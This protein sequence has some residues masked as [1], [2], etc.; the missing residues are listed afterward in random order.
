MT[1]ASS[2]EKRPS[3]L[4]RCF[5]K[6]LRPNKKQGSQLPPKTESIDS[7]VASSHN[8]PSQ[9]GT[10]NSPNPAPPIKKV[11]KK[12]PQAYNSTYV[13]RTQS[14]YTPVGITHAGN[15]GFFD[16]HISSAAG[17]DAS[18]G[19][20]APDSYCD[21]GIDTGGGCD[22]GGGGDSGGGG[23]DSGGG[24]DGGNDYDGGGGCFSPESLIQLVSERKAIKDLHPGDT[25]IC[26]ASG[27]TATVR[28]I[29]VYPIPGGRTKMIRLPNG[30]TVSPTHPI[31]DEES[32]ARNG[33][34]VFPKDLV[35]GRATEVILECKEV[36]DILLSDLN[37]AVVNGAVCALLGHE[38][39]GDTAHQLW[40]DGTRIEKCLSSLDSEGFLRGK[41]EGVRKVRQN[42]T[43]PVAALRIGPR[44]IECF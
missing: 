40:G 43:S 3:L 44:V 2:T 19:Y 39:Q 28:C 32:E 16:P 26:D 13:P 8:S 4:R 31:W 38:R 34:W 9:N 37:T 41:I 25:V 10:S 20:S 12:E 14:T 15:S 33:A 35:P 18:L 30:L 6:F 11:N 29:V 7:T 17:V 27:Q 5:S 42:E 21:P 22:G 24:C 1:M 36:Y 23:G